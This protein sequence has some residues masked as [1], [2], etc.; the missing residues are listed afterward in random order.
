MRRRLALAACLLASSVALAVGGAPGVVEAVPSGFTDSVVTD[1]GSL[2]TVE[3]LP[4]GRV[5]VLE[6]AGRALRIDDRDGSAEVVTLANFD[7]CSGSERGLLGFATDPAFVTS[8]FVYIYRTIPSSE[9][10]G[11]HNRVSRFFMNESG[12]DLASE[13]ILVDRISSVAG[14]HNGG[15]VEVGNDGYLYIAVGDAGR[16]PRGD[17]GSAGSNDAAQDNSLLNGKILR[18]LRDSGFAAP[19][20][21]FSGPGTDN[22]RVRGNSSA[23]PTTACREI[24]AFGL[25]N[26]YRFAFDPNTSATRF[27][28]N[29][30]GQGTREEV[31]E[32]QLG[33][34][35]GWPAREGRCPQGQNPPCAGPPA[36]VTDPITD[37]GRSDGLFITGGTFVPDGAW[38]EE[39]DG[40]YLISD[41][42]LGTTWAWRGETDLASAFEFLDA[43]SPTDMTFVTGPQAPEL[44]YVQQNGQVHKVTPPLGLQPADSGPQRYDA[45]ETPSRR[46]DS[47]ALT[48]AAP[49]R[50]G[51]TRLVDLDAPAGATA[52]V[53][54]LTLVRPQSDGAFATAWQPR[55]ERPSTSNLNAGAGENVA[56]ASIVPLDADGRMLVFAQATGH[57]IVD[58]SGFYFDADDAVRRGRFQA[59]GPERVVDTRQQQDSDNDYGRTPDGDGELVTVPLGGL[60]GIPNAT[61]ATSAVSVVVT[62]INRDNDEAG[63][64]TAF[65][66]GSS[67][68]SSSNVNVN[69]APDV[70]ANLVTVPLGVD[71]SISLYLENV[72]DVAV[73]V[74]GYFTGFDD[75]PGTDGRFHLIPPMREVDSRFD[76]GFGRLQAGSTESLDPAS[77]PDDASALAQ[78]LTLVR[79]GGRGFVT[80][81]PADVDRP[82]V[83]NVN[84]SG[85][86][87]VRAAL[88]LTR[89]G[90]G[91]EQFFAGDADADLLVDVFGWFE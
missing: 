75:D 33:A 14:N 26:P 27:F 43:D 60:V 20:N 64:V 56:N 81:F 44:W 69:A 15:D 32:S 54:N 79:T 77:V 36:G 17:S 35:Y 57:L 6:K 87:Q 28:I 10:G 18:V 1:V 31:N 3:A 72:D 66:T 40:N 16:D 76:V 29:D 30:V 38:P 2:T 23:T 91:A 48:P 39:Y 73:D 55:T 74:V 49:L 13:R 70:R 22:C 12:I 71:E 51:H 65:P 82:L 11:C 53:V 24:F 25:R 58:V 90:G 86:G 47:R 59:T 9:P 46:F 8:G 42:A 19:G 84:S 52:A 34:N 63:F 45:L 50:A 80:A 41:G 78:N 21:P 37:Y 4:D 68:P 5:V 89:L 83:S 88:A 61:D 62:A 85:S 7:V 67:Q